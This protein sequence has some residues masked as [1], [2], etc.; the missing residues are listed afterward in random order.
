[1]DTKRQGEQQ[2]LKFFARQGFWVFDLIASLK[3][4]WVLHRQNRHGRLY[5]SLS[6]ANIQNFVDHLKMVRTGAHL[7]AA[8]ERM[9]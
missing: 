3:T 4:V 7:D 5:G 8:F 6:A 2:W 1:M 9:K